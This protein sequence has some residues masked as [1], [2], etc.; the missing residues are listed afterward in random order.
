M[1]FFLRFYLFNFRERGRDGEREGE[2]HQSVASYT[3]PTEDLAHNPG[4]C[5]GWE[6]NLRPFGSQDG[7]QSS[8]PH[9]PGICNF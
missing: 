3:P 1:I 6:L 2:K 9:Q 4:M 5:P 7:A 8:E